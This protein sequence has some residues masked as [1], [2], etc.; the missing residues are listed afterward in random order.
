MKYI[1]CNE[2]GSPIECDEYTN[3]IYCPNCGTLYIDDEQVS[4]V[5][6]AMY[7]IEEEA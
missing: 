4:D 5:Y 1:N 2:C 7:D 3:E 6:Q